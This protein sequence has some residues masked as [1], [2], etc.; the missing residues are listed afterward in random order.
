[1]KNALD[2][3]VGSTQEVIT[4]GDINITETIGECEVKGIIFSGGVCG[5]LH[6]PS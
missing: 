4:D 1:M 3:L 2:H 6:P 5:M